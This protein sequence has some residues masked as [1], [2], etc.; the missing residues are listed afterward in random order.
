MKRD[1]VEFLMSLLQ[2]PRLPGI[3]NLEARIQHEMQPTRHQVTV[4]KQ[5]GDLIPH[6]APAQ[7]YL[8]GLSLC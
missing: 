3:K 7:A 5:I 1:Q 8:P 2:N 6:A 4:L